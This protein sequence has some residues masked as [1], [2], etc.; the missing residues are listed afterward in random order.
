MEKFLLQDLTTSK[1]CMNSLEKGRA[2][3]VKNVGPLNSGTEVVHATSEIKDELMLYL[4]FL[5]TSPPIDG[6]LVDPKT[7]NIIYVQSTVSKAHPIKYQ[8]LKDVYEDL[9]GREEFQGYSHIFLFLVSNNTYGQFTV[10][11]F[12]SED[13]TERQARPDVKVNQYVGKIIGQA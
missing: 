2:E 1:F 9:D 7:R 4:P 10:Q 11:P 8:P 13:G 12:Q 3:G 5:K 6:V